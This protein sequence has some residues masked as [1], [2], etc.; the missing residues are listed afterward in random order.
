MRGK[1]DSYHAK[2]SK[3]TRTLRGGTLDVHAYLAAVNA[4]GAATDYV[5]NKRSPK[6]LRER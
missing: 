5:N 1:T 6:N 2:I 3:R 4:L